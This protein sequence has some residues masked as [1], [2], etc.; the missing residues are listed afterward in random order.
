MEVLYI[1]DLLSTL[2]IGPH[3]SITDVAMFDGASNL[4]LAGELL[5]NNYTKVSVMR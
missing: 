2:K 1:L 4:Q 3:K 5:K